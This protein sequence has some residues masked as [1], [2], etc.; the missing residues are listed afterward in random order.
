MDSINKQRYIVKAA[1]ET[2]TL[3]PIVVNGYVR[4]QKKIEKQAL[5]QK[6]DQAGLLMAGAL[7]LSILTMIA[8]I[9]W[10]VSLSVLAA[11]AVSYKAHKIYK[12]HEWLRENGILIKYWNGKKE[13]V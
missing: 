3:K 11:S 12:Q 10:Q 6:Q 2:E 1:M 5:K 9:F 13:Y 7:S 8:V 4:N